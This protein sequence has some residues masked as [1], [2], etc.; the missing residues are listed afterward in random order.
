MSFVTSVVGA[1]VDGTVIAGSVESGP[2]LGTAVAVAVAL[3]LVLVVAEVVPCAGS[4]AVCAADGAL[5]I[6]PGS[7]LPQAG[8]VAA[9]SSGTT[10]S[11]LERIGREASEVRCA[12]YHPPVVNWSEGAGGQSDGRRWTAVAAY[13]LLAAA[14]QM[15]WLTYAPL[16]TASAHHYHVSEQA[17]GWLAEIF[18]LL[19]VV[20]AL[21]AGRLLDRSFHRWLAI[22]AVL[23]AV[24]G[25]LRLVAADY[26][27]ALAGQVLVAVA[28]PLVLNAVTKVAV[29]YL[30][31]RLRPHG[32]AVGSAGIFG[33]MVL[34]LVLGTMLGGSQIA[35]LL[36]IQAAFALI[37]AATLCVQLRH[38]GSVEEA[39][40]E[41]VGFGVADVLAVWADGG[42]RLLS[43]LLFLGF[44]V[45]VAVTTWLQ[46]LLHHYGVSANT[47]GSLLVA[48]VLAGA[49]ASALLPP[50]VVR[51]RVEG[52]MIATSVAFIIFGCL[53]LAFVHNIVIDA[54]CL[55][56]MGLLLITDLPVLLELSERRAGASAGTVAALLWLS[57]QLG[58]LVVALGVQL[59]I[60]DPAGAFILLA[61]VGCC[62]VPLLSRL[63][64]V[65][66]AA[67]AEIG[68]AATVAL[69][70]PAAP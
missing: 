57:G 51:R 42:V 38:R 32:I 4:V 21:P 33:G 55:I 13:A 3:A 68:A 34:A 26:A 59:L 66:A 58:G 24:G 45:F 27:W 41:I 16:T 19:Y 53:V 28:Q 50:M 15:L 65:L 40:R 64:P 17:I 1:G 48:M 69:S 47:A 70:E 14:T 25:V 10:R 20:L 46:P 63:A 35:A 52:S 22:G 61:L 5:T 67:R 56:P 2:V 23:T 8:S 11:S 37:A 39:H 62:A 9:A 30:P 7:G 6:V 18:P 49:V 36:E 60:H 29:A 54:F 12:V 31:V 43:G 44:G